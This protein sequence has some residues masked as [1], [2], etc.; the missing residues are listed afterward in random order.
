MAYHDTLRTLDCFA[1]LPG[2]DVVR[3]ISAVGGSPEPAKPGGPSARRAG[4]CSPVKGGVCAEVP[5]MLVAD[6]PRAPT[7][8]AST[9]AI[10]D[11]SGMR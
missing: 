8:L 9:T 6:E 1:K 3:R 7:P 2:D 10:A 4:E 11:E 5:A